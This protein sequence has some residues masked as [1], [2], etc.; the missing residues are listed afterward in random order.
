MIL[1]TSFTK[2]SSEIRMKELY[3]CL[4]NNISNEFIEKIILIS[5]DK[6]ELPET[7]KISFILT[8]SRPTF[9]DLYRYTSG[10]QSIIANAD[11]YF[12]DTLQYA[13]DYIERDICFCL[14]RFELCNGQWV[15]DRGGIDSWIFKGKSVDLDINFELGKL[16][17]DDRFCF[18]LSKHY[19]MFN[20]FNLVKSYHLHSESYRN[21]GDPISG[22]GITFMDLPIL[23]I[24]ERIISFSLYGSRICYQRGLYENIEI[25]KDLYK[26]W[27][28][29]VYTDQDIKINNT[30]V[31][32]MNK[33]NGFEGSYW[34]F[35]PMFDNIECMICRDAD[36]RCNEVERDCVEKWLGVEKRL[37]IIRD[38][39]HHFQWKINAGLFG[40]KPT[41]Q[42]NK[43]D[44]IHWIRSH[45]M[46]DKF[47]DQKYLEKYI[48]PVY[49]NSVYESNYP[50]NHSNNFLGKQIQ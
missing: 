39:P 3:S 41:S 11:I 22:H 50:S 48:Y 42:I 10:R 29:H 45:P 38:H 31:I 6:L 21:Y 2:Q 30:N 23:K 25:I 28:V 1:I 13:S 40:L 16:R 33:S 15:I 9:K 49:Q 32:Y 36:S 44:L 27:T 5:P 20:A 35:Y 24:G 14:R 12:D 47:G 26:D 37:H 46:D 19:N 18:E 7:S 43:N 4:N 34:R 8:S 17:C